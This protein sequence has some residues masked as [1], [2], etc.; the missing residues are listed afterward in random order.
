M[1]LFKQY[2]TK[3]VSLTADVDGTLQ[4][5]ASLL[6]KSR[7]VSNPCFTFL[8]Q[9]RSFI[10]GSK[11][12]CGLHPI[13]LQLL[14]LSYDLSASCCCYYISANI[15]FYSL[16]SSFSC[17]LLHNHKLGS[18]SIY[19]Q[20]FSTTHPCC[21]KLGCSPVPSKRV[22]TC[23]LQHFLFHSSGLWSQGSE[24]ESACLETGQVMEEIVKLAGLDSHTGDSICK[25]LPC[26]MADVSLGII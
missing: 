13:R 19:F 8:K 10:L 2:L 25:V 18:L 6:Q 26:F 24:T 1:I 17:L 23:P 22:F 7:C 21:G 20:C 5:C 15:T 4:A 12:Y 9:A 14:C 16:S 11:N 3:L